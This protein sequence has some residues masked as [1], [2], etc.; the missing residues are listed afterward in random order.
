MVFKNKKT[1]QLANHTD[2]LQNLNSYGYYVG[3]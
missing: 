2:I 1:G 3:K